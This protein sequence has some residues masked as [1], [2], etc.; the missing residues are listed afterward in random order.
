MEPQ[1]ELSA[2]PAEYGVEADG[3]IEVQAAETLGHY[4]N[5]LRIPTQR[6]RRLNRLEHG[7]PLPLGRMLT[8]DFS[9]VTRET[10]EATRLAYHRELQSDYFEHHHIQGTKPHKIRRGDSLW[11]LALRT[12]KIPVWLMRQYNPDKKLDQ[13]LPPGSDVIIPV[14]TA[15]GPSR[16]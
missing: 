4:A 12:Y 5:W 7:E 14:V 1:N 13:P 8:L 10:F 11:T 3:R 16:P 15:H 9:K 6:L 2:D